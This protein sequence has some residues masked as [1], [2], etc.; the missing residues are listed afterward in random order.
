MQLR[1]DRDRTRLRWWYP[2][3]NDRY[4]FITLTTSEKGGRGRERKMKVQSDMTIKVI[5]RD[6]YI[7][8]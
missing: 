1:V 7:A 6:D 5:L 3:R 4:T 8:F 2:E